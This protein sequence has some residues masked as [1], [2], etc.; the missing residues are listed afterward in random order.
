MAEGARP[1][2]ETAAILRADNLVKHYPATRGRGRVVH[3]LDGVSVALYPGRTLGIVG[4]SGSGKSTL[5]KL[6]SLLVPATSGTIY[7]EGQVVR[8]NH[9]ETVRHYRSI[10]QMVFQDP[11]SSLN[12]AKSIEQILE[13]PLYV[14]GRAHSAREALAHLRDILTLVGLTPPDDFLIKYP[15]ELS[16][17]Q[18][19]RVGIAR[20][21]ATGSRVL[22]ADEPVS[23]LDVSIRAGILNLLGRLRDEE[24]LALMYITHDLASARYLSDEVL[25]MYAAEGVEFASSDELVASP[26]HPYTQLLLSSVP[27]PDAALGEDVLPAA[28][29]SDPPNMAAPPPGCRFHPRCPYAMPICA[30]EAPKMETTATGH[31]VRCHLYGPGAVPKGQGATPGTAWTEGGTAEGVT[32]ESPMSPS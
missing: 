3:A 22:L 32:P 23:M 29:R 25:V 31:W 15:H 20:A 13:R 21:L 6:L 26:L 14:H 9:A 19:Q 12:P 16:G 4:E 11:F 10:V 30:E 24:H 17:G 7:L 8:P 28:A 18:R 5:A 1:T 27:D 2:A